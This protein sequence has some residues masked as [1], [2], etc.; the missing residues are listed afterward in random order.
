M[1]ARR[2]LK[3]RR[4]SQWRSPWEFEALLP[5]FAQKVLLT[6]P[7]GVLD[8]DSVSRC[9]VFQV[10]QHLQMLS[11]GYVLIFNVGPTALHFVA[12]PWLCWKQ[13]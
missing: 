9:L 5:F 1:F 4:K 2:I 12:I 8:V 10:S 11:E 3:I 6:L 13:I 7:C